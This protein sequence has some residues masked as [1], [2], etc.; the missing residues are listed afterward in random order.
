MVL[1]L[2]KKI[3]ICFLALQLA[4]FSPFANA[5]ASP[6]GWTFSGFDA[7][8]G[9]VSAIKN[10]AKATVTVS[11]K[12]AK[13]IVGGVIAGAAIP[14]AI[15]QL[16]GIALSAVDWILDP[17]NNAIKYKDKDAPTIGIGKYVF[18]CTYANCGISNAVIVLP[19]EGNSLSTVCTALAS[20]AGVTFSRVYNSQCL[21]PQSNIYG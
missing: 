10:G 12:I 20:R 4:F 5:N 16:S 21:T 7:V 8:S 6:S 2:F 1:R 18:G 17:T 13:G 14:L 11:K 19:Y 3:I 15:S 9:I